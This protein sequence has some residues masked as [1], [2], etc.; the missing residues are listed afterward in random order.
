MKQI[1]NKKLTLIYF[2]CL[3]IIVELQLSYSLNY[4]SFSLNPGNH[5][6]PIHSSLKILK[7]KIAFCIWILNALVSFWHL[8]GLNFKLQD[9]KKVKQY[10]MRQ[11]RDTLDW[12]VKEHLEHWF[13]SN[14]DYTKWQG[15]VYK[16]Y[17]C[18]FISPINY[19]SFFFIFINNTK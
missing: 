11:P 6:L 4:F 19:L 12:L 3:S 18:L 5:N 2:L 1:R 17:F 15:D 14:L 16:F 13:L 8:I 7:T 9:L 10:T